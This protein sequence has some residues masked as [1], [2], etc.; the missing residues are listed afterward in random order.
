MADV[1]RSGALLRTAADVQAERDCIY[2]GEPA[3][4]EAM[5]EHMPA[6]QAW[7]REAWATFGGLV[8]V[9]GVENGRTYRW[10]R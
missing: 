6:V 1:T 9:V 3:D 10:R 5:R 2:V 7:M 8:A 4:R